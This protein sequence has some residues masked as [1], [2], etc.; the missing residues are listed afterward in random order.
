[1]RSIEVTGYFLGCTDSQSTILVDLFTKGSQIAQPRMIND[2][3]TLAEKI[4]A[5]HGLPEE[6]PED[7][8]HIAIAAV[9]GMDVLITW[10]F[11]HFN[12]PFTRMKVRKIVEHAGYACPEICSP[13]ELLEV[14]K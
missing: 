13:E 8:L 3:Q 5:G 12:N 6:Y 10:N 4:I 2:A 7:A 1:M 9:N 14:D 11:A